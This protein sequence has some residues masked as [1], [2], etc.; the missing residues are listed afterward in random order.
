[1]ADRFTVTRVDRSAFAEWELR[2]AETDAVASVAP[3]KGGF[4]SA[5]RVGDESV[6]HLDPPE[7]LDPSGHVRGGIPVLFPIAGR[8]P[9]GAYQHA[10]RTYQLPLHGFARDCAWG[11]ASVSTAGAASIT[12]TLGDTQQTRERFPWPF[13]LELRWQIANPGGEPLP[14]HCGLHPY[15]RADPARK[16]GLRVHTDARHVFDNVT[17]ETR[18]L[19]EF[20]YALDF[21][22]PVVDAALLDHAAQPLRVE[23]PGCSPLALE[24]EGFRTVVVWTLREREFLCVEPWTGPPGALASGAGLLHVPPG[25]TRALSFRMTL[26]G[27]TAAMYRLRQCN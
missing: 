21:D 23:R 26:G 22:A 5:W 4:V 9:G 19:D 14:L 8:L 7:R 20:D 27:Q 12:M 13:A 10:G 24:W 11:V 6:L 18:A 1:M 15:F 17:G 3:A 2:D 25:E 16:T